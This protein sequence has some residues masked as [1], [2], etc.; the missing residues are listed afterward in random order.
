MPEGRERICAAAAF[1]YL[2]G[3][4]VHVIAAFHAF[5]L[6]CHIFE[7][8]IYPIMQRGET[9]ERGRDSK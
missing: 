3:T 9:Q 7:T 2:S 1:S 8:G 6:S 4:S 5:L